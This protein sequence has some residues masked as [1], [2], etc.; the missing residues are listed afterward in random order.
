MAFQSAIVARL[1]LTNQEPGPIGQGPD[2][3]AIN[4]FEIPYF[5]LEIGIIQDTPYPQ[6][7]MILFCHISFF[8]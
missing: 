7:K 6:P 8:P 5:F 4:A 2:S 3:A 1:P